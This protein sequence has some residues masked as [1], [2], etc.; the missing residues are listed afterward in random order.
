VSDESRSTMSRRRLLGASLGISYGI[1]G[2]SLLTLAAPL[3]P[4][5][6]ASPRN[7]PPR[8]G[9]LLVAAQGPK[10]GEIIAPEEVPSG[11]GALLAWPMDPKTRL[12]RNANSRNI[13]LLVRAEHSTWFSAAEQRRVADRVAAYAATCTHLCCTVSD[14]VT[15]KAEHGALLC[16]CHLS[17]FD[18]WDG[19][20]VLSGPAPRPLPALPL[21]TESNGLVVAAAFT[22]RVGC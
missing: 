10:S 5:L 12:V 21:R 8:P 15:A 20:R 11:S 9:D 22:A 2:A 16:P 6:K 1:A 19:A 3:R 13:I 7:A 17:V 14:W 18:P 4:G